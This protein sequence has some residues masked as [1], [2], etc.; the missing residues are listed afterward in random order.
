MDWSAEKLTFW[1]H[2]KLGTATDGELISTNASN[3][4]SHIAARESETSELIQ[5]CV[6]RIAIVLR[7]S[8]WTLREGSSLALGVMLGANLWRIVHV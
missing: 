3:S 8:R 6:D 1:S 7:A 2:V 5:Y 4:G